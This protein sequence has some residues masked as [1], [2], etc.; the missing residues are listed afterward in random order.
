MENLGYVL[1]AL[2]VMLLAAA[3]VGQ[4]MELY[5]GYLLKREKKPWLFVKREAKHYRRTAPV[6][7][8]LVEPVAVRKCTVYPKEAERE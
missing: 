7:E 8:N 1:A 5:Y 6:K 2:A 3:G 4:L